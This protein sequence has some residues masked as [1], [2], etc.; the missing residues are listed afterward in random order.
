MS[1]SYVYFSGRSSH[2]NDQIISVF[3]IESENSVTKLK[4]AVYFLHTHTKFCRNIP[5]HYQKTTKW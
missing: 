5:S 1:C 4:S 2:S 3:M